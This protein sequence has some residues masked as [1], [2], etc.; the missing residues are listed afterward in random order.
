MM[1]N[2]ELATQLSH[3][4]IVQ[5]RSIICNDLVWHTILA[6]ELVL[7]KLHDHLPGHI[8]IRRRFNPLG[9]V[10]NSY[11]NKTVIVRRL[12]FNHA[13]HVNSPHGERPW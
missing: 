12:R 11:E 1:R 7:D 13:N 6:Y 8:C 4:L 9:E 3:H 2:L 10:I 5:V